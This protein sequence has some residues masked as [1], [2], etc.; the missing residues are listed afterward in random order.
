MRSRAMVNGWMS[1]HPRLEMVARLAS[2]DPRT[3]DDRI[4]CLDQ[5]VAGLGSARRGDTDQVGVD[6]IRPQPVGGE[7]PVRQ[8]LV[9]ATSKSKRTLHAVMLNTRSG[10]KEEEEAEEE[11]R[12]VGKDPPVLPSPPPEQRQQRG[13]AWPRRRGSGGPA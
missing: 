11:E 6:E 10:E 1:L 12:S 7:L 8:P 13:R 5:D 3:S 4:V 9:H 2:S